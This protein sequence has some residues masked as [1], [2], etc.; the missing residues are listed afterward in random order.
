MNT[1]FTDKRFK[2]PHKKTSKTPGPKEK[3][4]SFYRG[5]GK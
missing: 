4:I 2:I 3:K 5:Q 1:A